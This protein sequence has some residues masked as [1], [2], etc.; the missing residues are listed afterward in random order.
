MNE[1]EFKPIQSGTNWKL[2]IACVMIFGIGFIVIN[3]NKIDVKIPSLKREVKV[4]QAVNVSSDCDWKI[5]NGYK[6]LYNDETKRYVVG[7]MTYGE[8][9]YLTR[10]LGCLEIYYASTSSPKSFSDSC[11]AKKLLRR[12]LNKNAAIDYK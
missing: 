12:Y 3:R 7:F 6:L 11:R 9:Q 1:N 5:P 10:S 4:D 2:V 8:Y